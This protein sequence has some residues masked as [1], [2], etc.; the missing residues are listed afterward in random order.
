M[1]LDSSL[2]RGWG[3]HEPKIYIDHAIRLCAGD[4]DL[5]KQ[6]IP[7]VIGIHKSALCD[8]AQDEL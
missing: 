7:T 1:L 5:D 2:E 8:H 4:S 6:A 3:Y